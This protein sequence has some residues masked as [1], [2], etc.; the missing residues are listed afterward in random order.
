ML[1]LYG[2]EYFNHR[3]CTEFLRRVNG[4]R[5][6]SFFSAQ[7]RVKLYSLCGKICDSL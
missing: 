4:V 2:W 5:V 7:L 6:H 1:G 3:V